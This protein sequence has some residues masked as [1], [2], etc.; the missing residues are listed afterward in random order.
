MR[1]FDKDELRRRVSEVLYYVW[2]PIGVADQPYAR[3][4]YE[5]YV[6]EVL[7]LVNE[8]KSSSVISDHLASI[9]KNSMAFSPNKQRCDGAASLLLEHKDAIE[10]G[11]A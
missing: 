7:Q 8:S 11:C 9:V 5:T 3:A 6:A 2:D 10:K 1:T 4:E